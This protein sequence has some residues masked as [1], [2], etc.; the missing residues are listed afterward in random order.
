MGLIFESGSF[1]APIS[2]RG[3]PS[4]FVDLSKEAKKY[5]Q[6]GNMAHIAVYAPHLDRGALRGAAYFQTQR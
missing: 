3:F 1:F 2:R 6:P 5:V 4:K